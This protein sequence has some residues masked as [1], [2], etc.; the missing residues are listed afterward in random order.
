MADVPMFSSAISAPLTEVAGVRIED[1]S[2]R[3]KW[4]TWE[5]MS[6]VGLGRCQRNGDTLVM[7]V[8]PG[9]WICVGDRPPGDDVVEVT[10]VRAALR[11][12]GERATDVLARVCAIDLSDA[13]T[14]DGAAARSLVAGVATEIVRDDIE[15]VRSYLLLMSRSFAESVHERLVAAAAAP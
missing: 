7:A 8:T 10:H 11:L 12:T 6:G 2:A 1:E 4:L 5:P 3:P 14:P 15:G 9:Q 13:M